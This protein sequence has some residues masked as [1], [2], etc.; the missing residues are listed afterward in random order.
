MIRPI[1][2]IVF[3]FVAIACSGASVAAQPCSILSAADVEK[4]SGVHV[5]EIPFNSKS[6]A[7]GRCANF[8][9]ENRRLYLGVSQ[10]AAADFGGEVASVPQAV[11]P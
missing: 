6:R 4:I 1:G 9:T 7:G 8:V 10:L 5:Q 11:Y 2:V 3:A